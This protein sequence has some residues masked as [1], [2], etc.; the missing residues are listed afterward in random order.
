M[1]TTNKNSVNMSTVKKNVI[2]QLVQQNEEVEES[3]VEKA[4][5]K[6][7]QEKIKLIPSV[8]DK[9]ALQKE[10]VNR[11]RFKTQASKNISYALVIEAEKSVNR[12]NG[13]VELTKYVEQPHIAFELEKGLFEF[14]LI[15]IGVVGSQNHFISNVYDY[16]LNNLCRNLDPNDPGVEN[17][18]LFK[19][20]WNDGFDA[21]FVPFLP[22][23]QLHPMR[24]LSIVKKRDLQEDVANN[25]Q[26][27][28]LY[29]CKRCKDKRFKITEIQMRGLD[30]PSTKVHVCLTCYYTFN[31]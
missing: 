12:Y 6:V 23:E 9:R 4:F 1:K 17:K 14:S 29:T 21:Y 8:Y 10:Y 19:M 24:W 26:T 11:Y 5:N 3:V 27:T 25:L 15:H 31:L 13:L 2:K 28:D 20:I 18:T 22:P 30:E 16:Q 7:I